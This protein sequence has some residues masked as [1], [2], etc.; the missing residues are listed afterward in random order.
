[1]NNINKERDGVLRHGQQLKNFGPRM[2]R[3]NTNNTYLSARIRNA[4]YGAHS[5]AFADIRGHSRTKKTKNLCDPLPT[6]IFHWLKLLTGECLPRL[7]C[8]AAL[9]LAMT[10][11]PV[12]A[13]GLLVI[14]SGAKQSRVNAFPGWIASPLCGSQ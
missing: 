14:A 2:A 12:I 1:L 13:G 5:R 8:F 9:R 7:D 11:L 4:M 6:L 10:T 3:I